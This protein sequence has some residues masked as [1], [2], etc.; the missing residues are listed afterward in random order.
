MLPAKTLC[1]RSPGVLFEPITTRFFRLA[2]R[3]KLLKVIPSETEAIRYAIAHAQP[4]SI[5][6]DCSESV[7]SAIRTVEECLAGERRTAP[8]FAH[9][10]RWESREASMMG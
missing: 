3:G 6:V 10:D 7:E 5:I 1:L 4:G 2:G 9:E 8:L